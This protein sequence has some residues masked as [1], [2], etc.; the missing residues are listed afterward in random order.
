M[1][2]AARTR[3][4]HCCALISACLA[5]GAPATAFAAGGAFVVD[6]YEIGDVGTCNVESWASLA[7]NNDFAAVVSPAC[8]VRL[9]VP[10]ELG[11]ELQRTRTNSEWGSGG[12]INGKVT[13]LPL[14]NGVGIGLSGQV[15]W[16]LQSGADTGGNFN[17]PV[18]F[19][20]G[21]SVRVHVNGGGLYDATAKL[22]YVTWGT[23]VEWDVT[24]KIQL[25]AE[26]YGQNGPSVSPRSITDPRFQTGIRLTPISNLDVDLIYGRNINGENSHWLTLG[27]NVRF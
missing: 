3:Y 7:K 4:R 16:A 11:G 25:I 8:V 6:D 10:I 9:G 21:R 12:A 5:L 27:F 20:L 13:L 24:R 18:T 15:N 17:I 14:T 19:D 1:H 26:V 23:G 22:A 2:A